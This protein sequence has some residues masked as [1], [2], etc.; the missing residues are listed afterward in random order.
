MAAVLPLPECVEK[1][2]AQ[3]EKKTLGPDTRPRLNPPPPRC[4]AISYS[5]PRLTAP[6]A[7]PPPC[8]TPSGTISFSEF[9]RFFLLVPQTDMIVE[10][11]LRSGHCPDL[12]LH[13]EQVVKDSKSSAWGACGR[14]GGRGGG[15]AGA[16]SEA[17]NPEP[18]TVHMAANPE[19]CTIHV[20]A[21]PKLCT[22]LVAV[23]PEP[24]TIHV[25]ANP[26]LCTVWL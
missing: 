11:W 9:R 14:E 26:K 1:K 10:Y 19:P 3:N 5:W 7:L 15:R 6:R 17:V 8:S 23:Y 25:A 12:Y 24:C 4:S 20:A 2:I 21:N 13:D 16:W 18:C 22:V